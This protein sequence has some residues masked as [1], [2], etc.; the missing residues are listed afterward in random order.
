MFMAR[1]RVLGEN[2]FLALPKW[3]TVFLYLIYKI[4]ECVVVCDDAVRECVPVM[5]RTTDSDANV[6][7][8]SNI[9]YIRLMANF[10]YFPPFNGDSIVF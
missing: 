7:L 5:H 3:G 2:T 9:L 10:F 4:S 8:Y 6:V 1:I